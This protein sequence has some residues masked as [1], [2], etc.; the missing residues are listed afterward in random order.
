MTPGVSSELLAQVT[1]LGPRFGLKFKSPG[2][3]SVFFL[4]PSPGTGR[5]YVCGCM[6][7]D[8]WQGSENGVRLALSPR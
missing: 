5:R 2:T 1:D 7:L 3:A 4:P 8:P 6:W